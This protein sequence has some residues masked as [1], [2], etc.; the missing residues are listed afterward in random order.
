[1]LNV[2]IIQKNGGGRI[3]F[4]DA[5]KA[6]TIFCVVYWHVSIFTGITDSPLNRIY[7]PFFLT[8][9]FFISGYFS[10]NGGT[11][12]LQDCVKKVFKRC[13][14]IL[15]PTIIMCILYSL[16]SGKT[17]SQVLFNNMKGGYWF[18]FVAFEI[19]L[20]YILVE[21]CLRCNRL[22]K[23]KFYFLL[24]LGFSGLTAIGHKWDNLEIYRLLS[25]YQVIK[26]L[27]FFYFGV[28]SR[29]YQD[30][31][32]RLLKTD[33][34]LGLGFVMMIVLYLSNNRISMCTQGY[35][36]IYLICG[37]FYKFK[38]LFDLN[39]S[40]VKSILK[41]GQSTLPIYFLHYFFLNGITVLSYPFQ[42]IMN[43][44]GWVVNGVLT[45]IT[46]LFI[47]SLCIFTDKIISISP[48]LHLYLFG[49]RR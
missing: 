43:G 16:Y 29:S 28:I 6:F 37:L 4:F 25:I 48:T 14:A 20:F 23:T 33:Y 46:T 18:T 31:F 40:I 17:A 8:L 7:M 19:Y 34:L 47:I 26:Y 49:T 41:I 1:M 27:P 12:T 42:I 15:I 9:F 24:I 22:Y 35:L 10:Y 13:K 38:G 45:G 3:E 30:Q 21:G 36:G 32:F 2:N 5:I 44:D 11:M 39:N